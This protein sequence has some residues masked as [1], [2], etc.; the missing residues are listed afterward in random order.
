MR[1]ELHSTP[2]WVPLALIASIFFVLVG[3]IAFIGALLMMHVSDGVIALGAC[4]AL[5]TAMVALLMLSSFFRSQQKL[6]YVLEATGQGVLLRS[7][8]GEPVAQ[9]ADGSLTLHHATH[10]DYVRKQYIRR[11]ALRVASR[12]TTLGFVLYRGSRV[13]P[14][15]APDIDRKL[16]LAVTISDAEFGALQRLA[17]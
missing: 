6:A 15:Q 14:Q 10:T 11:A 1:I 7:A 9:S 5:V 16:P 3:I 12:G 8:V 17:T 13:A 2:S 4:G